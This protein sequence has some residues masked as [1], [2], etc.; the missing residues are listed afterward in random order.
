METSR[1]WHHKEVCH[2]LRA[3]SCPPATGRRRYT[4][5]SETIIPD[6]RVALDGDSDSEKDLDGVF[7][8]DTDSGK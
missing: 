5:L 4:R 1:G 2:S 8:D 7:S 3:E 6:D